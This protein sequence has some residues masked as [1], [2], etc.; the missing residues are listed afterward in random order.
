MTE[1]GIVGIGTMGFLAAELLVKAGE[2]VVVSDVNTAVLQKAEAIGAEPASSPQHL[3]SQCDIIILILPGPPQIEGVVL[4]ENGLLAGAKPGQIIID[5]S[6]SDPKTTHKMATAV[7]NHNISYIDAPILGRPS[8]VGR[9]VLPVGGEFEVVERIRP[10]LNKLGKEVLHVGA[11]GAGHTLKL[12]NALMFSAINAIT[13]EMM[14]IAQK[15]SIDPAVL[16]KTIAGSDAATVSGLFK[17]TGRKMIER[18]FDPTFPID[19]LCKD[20]GL[21]VQM[22]KDLDAPPIIANAI[23]TMNELAQAKGLGKEDTSALVK[24][25]EDLLL[26]I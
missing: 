6:T 9:W 1:I 3:A 21:A 18:D 24:V 25:Y 7:A 13:A 11:L 2:S 10:L 22:A 17:E 20:N 19:L 5:M 12:L 15:S 26:P 4:G 23:Q 14:A 8:A 16:Y